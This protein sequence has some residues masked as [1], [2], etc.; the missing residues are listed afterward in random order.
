MTSYGFANMRAPVY[1]SAECGSR[2]CPADDTRDT[3][4]QAVA[5]VTANAPSY[6][7]WL[8]GNSHNGS[9]VLA[10]QALP[11]VPTNVC[12][13]QQQHAAMPPFFSER[14]A[15]FLWPRSP[16]TATSFQGLC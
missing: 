12:A 10:S 14:H 3:R 6:L 4:A 1:T 13:A 11:P 15:P 8:R 5:N 16:A 7:Q 9:Y 2:I